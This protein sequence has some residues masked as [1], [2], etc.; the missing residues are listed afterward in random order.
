M[1]RRKAVRFTFVSASQPHAGD[2]F[3]AVPMRHDFR[4]PTWASM[5]IIVHRRLSLP[6]DKAYS[7]WR[8]HVHGARRS[9]S[10]SYRRFGEQYRA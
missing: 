10:G 4:V 8:A 6:L 3:N 5:R 9:R 1:P 7:L 2:V